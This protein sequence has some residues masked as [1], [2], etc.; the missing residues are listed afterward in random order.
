MGWHRPQAC[1][2][3][4]ACVDLRISQIVNGGVFTVSAFLPLAIFH[5][6]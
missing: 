5:T 4:S 3:A 6:G 2:L 1:V